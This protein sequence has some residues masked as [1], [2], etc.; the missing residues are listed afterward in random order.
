MHLRAVRIPLESGDEELLIT[1]L[2][3]KSFDIP[4]FKE[5][6]FKRWSIETKYDVLK[7]KI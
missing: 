2:L 5:L 7:N 6:Y 4:T 1:N 3:D